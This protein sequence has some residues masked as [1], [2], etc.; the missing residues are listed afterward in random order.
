MEHQ[1]I[2]LLD[3]NWLDVEQRVHV[4]ANFFKNQ[5]DELEEVQL[6]FYNG[7]ERFIFIHFIKPK[8]FSFK[9]M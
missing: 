7:G 2:A 4:G 9:Q 5:R 6:S 8:T 1:L 3:L